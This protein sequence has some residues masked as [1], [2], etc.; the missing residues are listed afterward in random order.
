MS[1]YFTFFKNG[2][3]IP[4]RMRID[5]FIRTIDGPMEASLSVQYMT[6]LHGQSRYIATC[7][8]RD[9]CGQIRMDSELAVML[10]MHKDTI[11]DF[12]RWLAGQ[13]GV[14]LWMNLY[15]QGWAQDVSGIVNIADVRDNL[16]AS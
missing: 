13:L 7:S 14:S 4:D 8:Y 2:Q 3:A 10:H 12:A 16:R 9:R 5:R 11:T 15:G 6:S 1:A